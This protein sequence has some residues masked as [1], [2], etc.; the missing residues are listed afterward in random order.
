M[1]CT[2]DLLFK[3][4]LRFMFISKMHYYLISNQMTDYSVHAQPFLYVFPMFSFKHT[5]DDHGRK[6]NNHFLQEVDGSDYGKNSAS[7]TRRDPGGGC[8]S[9]RGGSGCSSC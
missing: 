6:Y 7:D 8:A 2:M 5:S 9:C 3:G 1:Q 4:I